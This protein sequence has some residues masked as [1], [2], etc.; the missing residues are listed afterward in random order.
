MDDG[1]QYL[2]FFYQEPETELH[3]KKGRKEC[4]LFFSKSSISLVVFQ[5]DFHRSI[6]SSFLSHS[7]TNS[8]TPTKPKVIIANL[9]EQSLQGV[10][11]CFVRN[12]KNTIVTEQN[13]ADV[14]LRKFN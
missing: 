1:C 4:I 5:D 9:N 8:A 12:S 10:C 2:V 11:L 7:V 13:I 3:Q 14:C 6:Y